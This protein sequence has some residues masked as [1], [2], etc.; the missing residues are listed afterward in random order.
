MHSELSNVTNRRFAHHRII[1]L[2]STALA[3][4]VV[5]ALPGHSHAQ[6]A[7]PS[8]LP[9]V[10]V[11][12]PVARRS[13]AAPQ[14]VV[15]RATTGRSRSQPRVAQPA[16][17]MPSSQAFI[18]GTDPVRGFVP[19]IS[20]SAMK[21]DTSLLETPQSVSVISR[22]NLD[23]RGVETIVEALQYTAGVATQ[24]GGKDPRFDFLRIRGFEAGNYR[25][26]LRDNSNPANFAVFRNETYGAQRVDVV[27][28][29]SSVLY[30]GNGPGGLI[31]IISK[32]PTREAFGEV[33][34]LVGTADRLQGAFDVGGPVSTAKDNSLFYRLTGVLRDSEAQI[35]K[36]SDKTKDDRAYIAPAVTWMPNEATSLPMLSSRPSSAYLLA[37]YPA[38][39]GTVIS[40]PIDVTAMMWPRRRV[41]MC[42]NT[43]WMV[44]AAP[45]TLVS[46]CFRSWAS[47][48]SSKTPSRP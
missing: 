37:Q 10:V 13:A 48:V 27:K 15:R 23:A 17:P 3:F 7:A 8:Q 36:F 47:E 28:G 21:S 39:P 16:S 2:L 46:N 26:G 34:G 44:A 18:R 32:R 33:V 5:I 20:A 45:K 11:E 40:P 42:G 35:A 38:S 29:P 6:S 19:G 22:E 4:P 31:D 14:R 41:R 1:W 30:G 24:T 25:D 9:A 43:A 12:Q